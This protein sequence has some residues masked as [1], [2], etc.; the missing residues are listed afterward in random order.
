MSTAEPHTAPVYFTVVT[1]T[2][3]DA[4]FFPVAD[5]PML[6]DLEQ[7]QDLCDHKNASA[8]AAN[9]PDRYFVACIELY[10]EDLWLSARAGHPEM[11]A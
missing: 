6:D 2:P 9:E 10:D 3:T 1:S 11:T 8:T 4:R 5:P 7:A